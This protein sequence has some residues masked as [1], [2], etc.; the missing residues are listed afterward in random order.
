MC[1]LPIRRRC[2]VAFVLVGVASAKRV[3]CR[4]DAITPAEIA[5]DRDASPYGYERGQDVSA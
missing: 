2:I 4:V 3:R 1:W 5:R